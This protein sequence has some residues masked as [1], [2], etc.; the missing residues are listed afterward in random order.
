MNLS[1]LCNRNP[2]VAFTDTPVPQ[3][4]RL[5]RERHVGSLVIV[6]E[7]QGQR[8]PVG[9]LTDRDIVVATV[10]K[11]VDPRGLTAGDIMSG[12]LV[13]LPEGAAVGDAL[14]AMRERGIRRLPIIGEG[15]A[16]AGIVTL[17]DMLSAVGAELMDFVRVVDWQ[18][19]KEAA[20]RG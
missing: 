18:R 9:I 15:G 10:A 2:V 12:D 13:T 7:R 14:G 19:A 8:F 6:R 20:L 1:E 16:L 5:M 17:D 11:D 4:A 3:A